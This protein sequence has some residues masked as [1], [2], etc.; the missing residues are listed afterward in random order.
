M[1]IIREFPAIIFKG[2]E[3]I[4]SFTELILGEKSL[5]A[6]E[7]KSIRWIILYILIGLIDDDRQDV[8]LDHVEYAASFDKKKWYYEDILAWD[9]IRVNYQTKMST[10]FAHHS[11]FTN[12]KAHDPVHGIEILKEFGSFKNLDEMIHE[13]MH[14]LFKKFTTKSNKINLH[15]TIKKNVLN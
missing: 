8:W 1:S 4:R 5:T 7:F 10:L 6:T 2:D 13:S 11:S 3:G 9:K 15:Y 12:P 14:Q